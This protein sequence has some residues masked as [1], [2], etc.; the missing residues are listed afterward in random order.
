[1]M[2]LARYRL[3]FR[4]FRLHGTATGFDLPL[5]RDRYGLL[6]PS[7]RRRAAGRFKTPL[8]A[9]A[10]GRLR[11]PRRRGV[12]ARFDLRRRAGTCARVQPLRRDR[13]TVGTPLDRAIRLLL[14][15]RQGTGRAIPLLTG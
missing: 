10:R 6:R 9:G 5:G 12:H 4:S 3:L 13:L 15:N 7:L 2:R 1:M 14:A 8:G 11:L